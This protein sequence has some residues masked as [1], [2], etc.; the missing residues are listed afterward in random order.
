M[1]A[2]ITP[3]VVLGAI[4]AEHEATTLDRVALLEDAV[5]RLIAGDLPEHER[6]QARNAAHMLAGSVGM[7]GFE[8]SSAAAHAL[9]EALERGVTPDCERAHVLREHVAAM[10]TE[11]LE[12]GLVPD[13]LPG[14]TG[15]RQ[16]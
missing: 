11:G 12:P 4:W 3:P 10:R 14:V 5:E 2:T 16:K 7:F 8:R 1:Q 9:E 15:L 6:E 13:P